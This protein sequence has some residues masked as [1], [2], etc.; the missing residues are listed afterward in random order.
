MED[1]K[2]LK[3]MGGTMRL[4]SYPVKIQENTQIYDLYKETD[5]QER[6]RHR[7]EINPDYFDRLEDDNL[8]FTGFYNELAETLELRDHPFFVGVQFHPEFKSTPWNPC[9]AYQGLINA[10]IKLKNSREA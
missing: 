10:T 4:G 1:H 5:I 8:V 6:H 9:P 3:D 2:N 7:Y